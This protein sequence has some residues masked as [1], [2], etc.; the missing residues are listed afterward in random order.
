VDADAFDV[1]L[2]GQ[3]FVHRGVVIELGCLQ[4]IVASCEVR[5]TAT[6]KPTGPV[7]TA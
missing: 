4:R 5:S 3:K 2:H 7:A 6:L 1:A